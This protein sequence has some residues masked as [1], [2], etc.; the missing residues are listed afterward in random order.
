MIQNIIFAYLIIC[1]IKDITKKVK[2]RLLRKL[3]D[4]RYYLQILNNFS[5]LIFVIYSDVDDFEV[6]FQVVIYKYDF[7]VY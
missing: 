7:V 4:I 2:I 5:K 1:D 6:F 3:R